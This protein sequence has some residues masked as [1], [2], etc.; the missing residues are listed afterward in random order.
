M[1]AATQ[2]LLAQGGERGRGDDE[3]G[4]IPILWYAHPNANRYWLPVEF[5]VAIA[6]T[7]KQ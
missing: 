4:L 7:S 2:R 1:V 5:L 3:D 6:S